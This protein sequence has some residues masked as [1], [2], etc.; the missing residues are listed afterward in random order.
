MMFYAQWQSRQMGWTETGADH[1]TLEAAT[2]EARMRVTNG[3]TADDGVG[4]FEGERHGAVS[5]VAIVR[6][7][8]SV[9][10]LPTPV[11]V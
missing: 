9:V 7:D 1:A 11:V 8:G 6:V 2:A 4:L 10:T 3:E 5:L